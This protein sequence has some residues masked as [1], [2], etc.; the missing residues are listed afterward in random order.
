MIFLCSGVT[1]VEIISVFGCF[2]KYFSSI[3]FQNRGAGLARI[4]L[5]GRPNEGG[6][7]TKA[8]LAIKR[9]YQQKTILFFGIIRLNLIIVFL[10]GYTVFRGIRGIMEE[11]PD[12]MRFLRNRLGEAEGDFLPKTHP[13]RKRKILSV[14][15]VSKTLSPRSP[16]IQQRQRFCLLSL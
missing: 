2:F 15:A 7:N 10:N 9:K 6:R 3:V 4:R 16:L 8:K 11:S 12:S 14:Q 1:L 5:C 13:G